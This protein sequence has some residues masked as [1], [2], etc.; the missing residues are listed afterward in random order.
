MSEQGR[1]IGPSPEPDRL[2]ELAGLCLRLG[3]TAFGGP[4]AHIAMLE[5]E[6]VERRRW[7]SRQ[8]FLDLLGATNLIP[9][10][11][12][13]EMVM[14]VGHVRGGA[15]GL[16]VAGVCFIFPA[17]LLTGVLAWAYVTFGTRPEAAPFLDG[18]KPVVLAII[19]GAVWRLGK[20]AVKGWLLAV[21]GLAVAGAVLLGV[22]EV[23]ALL[24]GGLLGMLLLRW[25]AGRSRPTGGSGAEKS[26]SALVSATILTTT[27]GS[28]W[29]GLV[30]RLETALAG[31]GVG[32]VAAAKVA[33]GTAAGVATG[34]V[35]LTLLGLFFLKVGATLYGSGYVLVAF[36]EGGLVEEYGWLTQ[37]QLL[38]AIAFGQLTPGP[39]LSTATFVGYL[40]RGVPG[41]L[42]ATLGIFLPSFLFVL[43]VNP[44]V[45]R[46]RDSAWM[47]A[48]L[49]A[50]NAAA[51]AL[52]LAV[53][54]QLTV[55]T[56]NTWPSALLAV[57]ALVASLR[58]KVGAIWL[59]AAG[60]AAGWLLSL[61]G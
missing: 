3:V 28:L 23:P 41:A 38:D 53:A 30:S 32:S 35:S 56:V 22:S 31:M 10:P 44:L 18:I 4:A 24:G 48:F 36:L 58:F 27:D 42:V 57:A 26:S 61:V 6:V 43:L 39:V 17:V 21:L 5:E 14:H 59:V 25:H 12:S 1:P 45:P 37:G 29:Q 52:M 16:F 60:A 13:T 46:L 49:D 50:V 54:L 47:A 33:T 20:K 19:A 55:A 40:I 9:G 15:R 8:H 2:R 7:L 51:V 11:N 34:A